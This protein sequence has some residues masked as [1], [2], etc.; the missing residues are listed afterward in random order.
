MT[1]NNS[2][3]PPLGRPFPPGTSG[4][5]AGRPRGA[6]NR[7][8]LL[9]E[10]LLEGDAEEI[11]RKLLESAKSGERAS[12]R[13]CVERILPRPRERPINIELP[14][15]NSAADWAAAI[16]AIIDA[17]TAGDI[18]L[19]DA[20]RLAKLIDLKIVAVE[21]SHHARGVD[22]LLRARGLGIAKLVPQSDGSLSP[23][24]GASTGNDPSTAD[25][26]APKTNGTSPEQDAGPKTSDDPAGHYGAPKGNGASPSDGGRSFERGG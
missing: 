7:V 1:E 22:E 23:N 26:G 14:P 10:A 4:N 16:G 15:V 19:S 21:I 6:R 17:A 20:E 8:T 9:A 18:T 24:G 12:L 2:P 5:R 11:M 13:L 25:E 3:R